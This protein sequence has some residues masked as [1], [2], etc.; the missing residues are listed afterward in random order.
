MY[1]ILLNKGVGGYLAR[2]IM[3]ALLVGNSE[4]KFKGWKKSSTQRK[5]TR[6]FQAKDVAYSKTPTLELARWIP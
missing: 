1:R 5:E 3:K 4:L 2:R 6:R